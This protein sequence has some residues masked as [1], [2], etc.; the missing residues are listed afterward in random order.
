VLRG[1]PREEPF[2][3]AVV[4]RNEAG[5]LARVIEQA[6]RAAAPGD[7]V[8]F[9]D[10]A[11]SDDSAEI[12]RRM[13]AEVIAE[14][15]CNRNG[16]RAL[17]RGLHL[18]RRWRS[19]R[20]GAQHLRHPAGGCRR[21]R[22]GHGRGRLPDQPPA[23]DLARA[24]LAADRRAA[25]R[26]RHTALSTPLERAARDRRL[27]ADR[28]DSAGLWGRDLPEP[29]VCGGWTED[30]PRRPRGA[31]GG[32]CAGTRTSSRSGPPSSRRSSTSPLTPAASTLTSDRIGSGGRAMCSSWSSRS[33][34]PARRTPATSS[35]SPRPP[36][37]R[38][39][40]RMRRS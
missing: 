12:A 38:S 6:Q 31:S 14:G 19:V 5:T 29:H 24:V 10:S 20:V 36:T 28:P 40:R 17:P 3:L 15:A 16:A 7:R 26:P 35:A 30:L 32:R 39:R 37:A 22:G 1:R 23:V 9:V 8:W 13:G 4:G 25:P 2:T 33:R 34:L 18:L 27:A 11:S 21:H